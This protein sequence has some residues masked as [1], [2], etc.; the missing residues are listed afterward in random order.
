MLVLRV[1]H[2]GAYELRRER[3]ALRDSP[4]GIV[5]LPL[6]TL[7]LQPAAANYSPMRFL[8]LMNYGIKYAIP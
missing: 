7:R 8:V 2:C 1:R 6:R 5:S 3:L 4:L